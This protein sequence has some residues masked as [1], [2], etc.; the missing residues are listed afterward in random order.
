MD[1]R[2]NSPEARDIRYHMHAYTNARKHQ[3]TGPLVIEKGDGVYVEDIAGNRYIEAMAGL[4]SVAVGFSEK[5]LVEAATRQMSKLPFYHDFGSKAH[6]PLIDLA[7][8]LVQMA[9]VPMSKAYF[10]NSGSEANDTAIK[11]IWYRS[12]ALGQPTRKKIISR[13][14]GYHGVTIASASLTG[15]PNNHLSF[16]LPIANILHTS[17]PHHWRDAEPGESEEQFS[18]RLADDLEKLILAEGPET[19]AAFIGEPIMGAGGVVIP[20]AGYWGKIQAVLSKYDILLVADEVICGFGRTGEMFGSQTFGIK[21]DIMVLSKQI[22]SSYLPISALLINDK[23]FEPIADE[24]DRI[25]T[26]GHGFTGGGHPVAAAV[27][28]ENLKLIE[29]RD[30][31]GNARTVGAHLQARLRKLGSH[32]LVGEVRGVG[33]IA[34]VELVAD[35]ASKAPWGKPAALGA[36]VNGFMQHNGVISRNMGDA[37]AFCPPMIITE[38]QVDALV[39]A[40]ERSLEAALPQV[41]PRD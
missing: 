10:T 31:V 14:R 30:L 1:A 12:N 6:S 15:L 8:K 38:A 23:V 2:P 35:K 20:P 18:S 5:R 34:A 7:E 39:D 21:P 28:L 32:P 27:A 11:M 3:E 9:P 24:S 17:T 33:L 37:I 16:D 36:L 19:I 41:R 25:G 26:F 4:W 22:S 13:K 29:E 40:F